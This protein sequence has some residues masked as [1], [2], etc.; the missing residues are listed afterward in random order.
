M[1]AKLIVV[2]GKANKGEVAIQLPATIGRSREAD[3]T[4]GHRMISRKHC[5]AYLNDG[6]MMI[7]DMGSLNGVYVRGRRVREAPLPPGEKFSIG[8]ITFRVEYEYS[9]DLSNLPPIVP[10]EATA[11]TPQSEKPARP[12][13]PVE[14]PTEPVSDDDHGPEEDSQALAAVSSAASEDEELDFE[15]IE[16]GDFELAVE[17]SLPES[18]DNQGPKQATPKKEPTKEAPPKEEKPV[19][20]DPEDQLFDDFLNDLQ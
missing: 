2:G 8:P 9:G 4:V 14:F 11:V 20:K 16:D 18:A 12:I 10:A 3:L 17:E 19:E 15:L 7:R 6:L 13:E 5:E 1:E